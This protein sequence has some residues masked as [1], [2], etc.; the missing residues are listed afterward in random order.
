MVLRY[1]DDLSEPQV[2]SI[3]GCSVGTVKSQTSKALAKLRVDPG[4]LAGSQQG[5]E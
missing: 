5:R 3:L 4:I 1:F 2:A